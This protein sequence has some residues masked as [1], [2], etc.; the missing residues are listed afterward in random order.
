[1]FFLCSTVKKKLKRKK[2]EQQSL[3]AEKISYIVIDKL[4]DEMNWMLS[5]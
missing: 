2:T 4:I 3:Q 5:S 1:M